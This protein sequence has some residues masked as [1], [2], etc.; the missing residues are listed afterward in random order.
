MKRIIALHLA[1]VLTVYGQTST[2]RGTVSTA[3]GPVCFA[4]V[5]FVQSNDTTRRFSAIT[6]TAGNYKLDVATLVKSEDNLPTKFELEQNYP[7]PFSSST[8]ISYKLVERSNISVR[9]YDVLGQV[10]KEFKTGSQSAGVHGIVWDGTNALGKKVVPGVYFYQLTMGS[11]SQA[12]KM[13]FGFGGGGTALLS[14]AALASTNKLLAAV[15]ASQIDSASYD[16]RVQETDSTQPEIL[17][18]DFGNVTIHGDTTLNLLV[19]QPTCASGSFFPLD[20]NTLSLYN[21]NGNL[22]DFTGK[23]NGTGQGVFD[24]SSSNYCQA[25]HPLVAPAYVTIPDNLGFDTLQAFTVEALLTVDSLTPGHMA[26]MMKAAQGNSGWTFGFRNSSGSNHLAFWLNGTWYDSD[27]YFPVLSREIYVAATV[28]YGNG[29]GEITLYGGGAIQG[30]FTGLTISPPLTSGSYRIA[31]GNSVPGDQLFAAIDEIRVSSVE[32]DSSDISAQYSKLVAD[33]IADLQVE[34]LQF[35]SYLV[36]RVGTWQGV[37]FFDQ[38]LWMQTNL[39][40]DTA[41]FLYE[42]NPNIMAVDSGYPVRLASPIGHGGSIKFDPDS[43]KL[44]I[45]DGKTAWLFRVDPITGLYDG[46]VDLSNFFVP[47]SIVGGLSAIVLYDGMLYTF[48]YLA[49]NDLIE[50]YVFS[51]ARLHELANID[52]MVSSSDLVDSF[53]VYL[54]NTNSFNFGIQGASV[55]PV[56]PRGIWIMYSSSTTKYSAVAKIDGESSMLA[57]RAQI[58]EYRRILKPGMEDIGIDQSDTV[59]TGNEVDNRI[60][61]FSIK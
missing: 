21:F 19:E 42:I 29:S 11:T 32:R 45:A 8:S 18:K 3:T 35:I 54:G 22:Q 57:G 51:N 12:K 6:D 1:T 47:D 14:S 58:L 44:W 59:Y 31:M 46:Y 4:S 17:A 60:Y 40:Y 50:S 7:N 23:H 15:S 10:V 41:A 36:H 39:S 53:S 37:T 48:P 52:G 24:F 26:I 25:F 49:K 9:I 2:V 33:S 5:S 61:E 28:K 43:S 13:L 27:I 56:D 20:S 16:V 30:R 55:D 34:P 38:N